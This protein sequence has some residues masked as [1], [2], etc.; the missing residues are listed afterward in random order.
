MPSDER[1][2]YMAW[3]AEIQGRLDAQDAEADTPEACMA[4]CAHR[5]ACL[6]AVALLVDDR[7]ARHAETWLECEECGEWEEDR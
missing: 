2:A 7:A 3:H 4:S 6:R 5:D 1:A